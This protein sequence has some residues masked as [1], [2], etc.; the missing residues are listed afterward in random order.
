MR[1]VRGS[2][3]YDPS[4]T[5]I[6]VPTE[7]LTAIT[8]TYLLTC[9]SATNIDNSG[10]GFTITPVASPTI[11]SATIPLIPAVTVPKARQYSNGVYQVY[12]S[13]DEVTGII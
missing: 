6:T 4:L 9:Q 8:N 7:P 11:S 12:G 2:V 1:I 10:N 13:F 3:V 5:T